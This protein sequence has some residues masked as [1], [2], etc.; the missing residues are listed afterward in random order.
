MIEVKETHGRSDYSATYTLK[1]IKDGQQLLGFYA[2]PLSECPEDATLERDLSYAFDVVEA[3]KLGVEA[4][5]S[6][7]KIK[8]ISGGKEPKS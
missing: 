1:I 4:G 2:G 8:F 3:F 6:G 5:K 7:E